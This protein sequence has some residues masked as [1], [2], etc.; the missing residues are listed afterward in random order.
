MGRADNTRFLEHFR[1]TIVASQLLSIHSYLGQPIQ[2]SS[3]D[4]KTPSSTVQ[5]SGSS[6][7]AGAS[8]T[9]GC[10]FAVAWLVRWAKDGDDSFVGRSRIPI[11]MLVVAAMVLLSYGYMGRQWLHYLRQQALAE[12]SEF[13]AKAQ[14]LDQVAAGAMTLVQ[15]VELV[16]RG[17]R[18]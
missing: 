8:V 7:L 5:H 15:E 6:T 18:M 17:Y 2:S 12:T 10:V 3:R 9:L 4:S 16:S 14:E 11:S 1:Y 13:V